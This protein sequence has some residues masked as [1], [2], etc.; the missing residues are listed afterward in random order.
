MKRIALYAG[1]AVLAVWSGAIVLAPLT[2]WL[3]PR[4]IWEPMFGVGGGLLLAGILW[5]S[6]NEARKAS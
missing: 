6:W 1:A 5:H 2:I 3:L 4:D